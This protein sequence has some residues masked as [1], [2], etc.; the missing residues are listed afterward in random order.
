MPTVN[1]GAQLMQELLDFTAGYVAADRLGRAPKEEDI[2]KFF[3]CATP[4]SLVGK[5]MAHVEAVN[6]SRNDS[7]A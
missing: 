6:K 1:E 3:D 7:D 4:D 2:Q 5:C